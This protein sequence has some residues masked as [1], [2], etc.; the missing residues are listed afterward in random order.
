LRRQGNVLNMKATTM[1]TTS[2]PVRPSGATAAPRRSPRRQGSRAKGSARTTPVARAVTTTTFKE[3]VGVV[4]GAQEPVFYTEEDLKQ[5]RLPYKLGGRPTEREIL[6]Q[7]SS[8]EKVALELQCNASAERRQRKLLGE[9]SALERRALSMQCEASAEQE[10]KKLLADVSEAERR[11]LALQYVASS[12]KNNPATETFGALLGGVSPEEERAIARQL[13]ASSAEARRKSLKAVSEQE[14]RA[15]ELQCE[16]SAQPTEQERGEEGKKERRFRSSWD[17]PSD[18]V[19][20]Y[21]KEGADYLYELGQADISMNVDMA[22]TAQYI[23][24]KFTMGDGGLRA[25][26]ADGSLRK[27]EFR[28]FENIKGD[29]WIPKKFQDK[30]TVH[31]VKNYLEDLTDYM[32]RVPLILGIF[33]GKGQ[34][35]SFLTELVLK[36]LKAEAVIMSAGELEDEVAGRPAKLIRDRYRKA[37]DLSKVRGKITALVINDL[38]AGVGRFR[39]TQNTVNSQMVVGTL[40][41][42]CDNPKQISV[43]QRWRKNDVI[44]RVPIIITANDLNTIY[45]PLLRDGRMEKFKWEPSRKDIFE[46]VYT[47]FREDVVTPEEVQT[48]ID[49]FPNQGLDFFGALKARMADSEVRERMEAFDGR[50]EGYE[51]KPLPEGPPGYLRLLMKDLRDGENREGDSIKI[52]VSLEKLL[53]EGRSLVM[54]QEYVNQVRLANDYLDTAGF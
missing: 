45:A 15:L 43:G 47:M 32:P 51:G 36:R 6:Q 22:Q 25:D 23:D 26:I 46:M 30:L 52:E 4:E 38:D 14:R 2:G 12:R 35:K 19:G 20:K 7:I 17:A 3:V 48:V 40:M 34:G 49:T 29:Y 11:A 13:D 39:E 33:G 16:T 44:N 9:L 24:K 31:I 28:K 53:E 18:K 37:A 1:V 41:N 27:F 5:E 54:E 50:V 42:I 21:K 10:Q 8:I